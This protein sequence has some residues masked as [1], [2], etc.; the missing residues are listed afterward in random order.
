LDDAIM[1]AAQHKEL[2]RHIRLGLVGDRH[3]EQ[4][5]NQIRSRVL[6][7]LRDLEECVE[8]PAEVAGDYMR[9]TQKI[10]GNRGIGTSEVLREKTIGDLDA[11][12]MQRLF[13]RTRTRRRFS[14]EGV[15]MDSMGDQEKLVH[16]SLAENGHLY[17]STF[18]CL[19]Q[20]N[21][22]EAVSYTA[23]E[24]RFAIFKG[25]TRTHFLVLETVRG[26]LIQQY[27]KMLLLLQQ[28]IPLQRN[29]YKSEDSYEIPFIAF[30][31]LTANAFIH[32]SYDAAIQTSIQIELFDDRL[33]IKSP[34]LFPKDL[35]LEHIEMSHI[36]NPG[37]A[38]IF[39]LYGHVEKSGTGINR[40][41]AA[42]A[43]R[44][45]RPPVL[46]QNVEHRFT[47]LSIFK[48]HASGIATSMD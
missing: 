37:I 11:R 30:K 23:A 41:K 39:F 27:E 43:A 47:K 5:K 16:L 4:A 21:Q 33:D 25:T 28:H 18:L 46:Y 10:K 32:R 15:D 42:L 36:L 29:V 48:Q 3:A 26:N 1:H 7:L 24:S 44:G 19:G 8:K 12:D 45:M 40:A 38:A 35:T 22:I 31:E 14:D 20:S 9:I 34:G 17:K 2:L 6:L 13:D